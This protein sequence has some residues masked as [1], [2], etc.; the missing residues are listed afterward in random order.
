MDCSSLIWSCHCKGFILCF[1]NFNDHTNHLGIFRVQPW[2]GAWSS[3]CL[4]SSQGMKQTLL[5]LEMARVA[6][7]TCLCTSKAPKGPCLLLFKSLYSPL[8]SI[9]IAINLPIFASLFP[10]FHWE[11]ETRLTKGLR[12]MF[13]GMVERLYLVT[14]GVTGSRSFAYILISSRVHRGELFLCLSCHSHSLPHVKMS[15]TSSYCTLLSRNTF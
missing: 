9:F 1:P 6:G 5:V 13:K 7:G 2:D 11:L 3:E 8:L 15:C 12:S 14:C 4:T 10:H